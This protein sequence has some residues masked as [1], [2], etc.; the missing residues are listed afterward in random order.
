MEE[1]STLAIVS[2][3]LQQKLGFKVVVA[4]SVANAVTPSRND[5]IYAFMHIFPPSEAMV[6]A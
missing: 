1:K 4:V 6:L 5:T 3:L 2:R